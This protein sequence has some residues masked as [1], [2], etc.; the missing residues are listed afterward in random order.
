M[1]LGQQTFV[2]CGKDWSD[3]PLASVEML[4]LKAN[5][6]ELI[7]IRDFKLR[8]L[9]IFCQVNADNIC[10]LGGYNYSVGYQLSIGV[11]LN[12]ETGLVKKIDL[13]IDVRFTCY[14]Q[15]FLKTSGQIVSLVFTPMNEVHMISYNKAA[16][17]VTTIENYG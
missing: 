6:W 10:I 12:V 13:N 1:V 2:A 15:S 11:L 7:E 9:P 14:S 4:R 8:I 16:N 17:T 5:A 3:G